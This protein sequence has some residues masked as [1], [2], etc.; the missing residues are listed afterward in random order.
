MRLALVR[1]RAVWS[2]AVA[3]VRLMIL[4]DA[5]PMVGNW[6]YIAAEPGRRNE[7]PF[8]KHT[9]DQKTDGIREREKN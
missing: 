5:M 6:R 9:K 4:N 3:R 2:L 8:S 1:A 7:K